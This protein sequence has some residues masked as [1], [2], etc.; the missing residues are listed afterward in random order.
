MKTKQHQQ[1]LRAI[2]RIRT[3]FGIRGELK[4]ESYARSAEEFET[5]GTVLVGPS[6]DTVVPKEI[7]SVTVRGDDICISFNGITDRTDAERYRGQYLFVEESLR[8]KLPKEK[9]FI[10]ELID[11]T[12]QNEEGTRLG[13]V[14]SVDAYPAQMVYTVKTK[15]GNVLLPAVK[16]FIVNV[17]VESKVIVVR[18]PEGLFNGEML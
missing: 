18:P 13:S 3:V 2:A 15:K 9:F 11:C 14:V 17:D 5:V 10:D 1:T 16:E 12:V 4:I 6:D 8:K 7:T